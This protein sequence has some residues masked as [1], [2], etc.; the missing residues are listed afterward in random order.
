MA[1]SHLINGLGSKYSSKE[2]FSER[3]FIKRDRAS[4]QVTSEADRRTGCFRQTLDNTC[5]FYRQFFMRR[6]KRK[7]MR[8]IAIIIHPLHNF[9]GRRCYFHRKILTKLFRQSPRRETNQT[10]IS[11]H[12][13]DVSIFR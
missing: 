5:R 3:S 11:A 9:S 10:M 8:C 6:M 4:A 2:I 7:I 1:G 13:L 12:R